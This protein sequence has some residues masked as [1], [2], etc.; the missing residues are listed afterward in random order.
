MFKVSYLKFLDVWL[1]LCTSFVFMTLVEV[2]FQHLVV[3][4]RKQRP[5]EDEKNEITTI[6]DVG[7]TIDFWCKIIFPCLYLLSATIIF[8]TM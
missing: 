1:C 3:T 7:Q 6:K 2:V 4:K 5:V 8:L